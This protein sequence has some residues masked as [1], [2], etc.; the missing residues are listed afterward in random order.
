[1]QIV[2][3]KISQKLEDESTKHISLIEKWIKTLYKKH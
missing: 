3:D 2:P 1:M